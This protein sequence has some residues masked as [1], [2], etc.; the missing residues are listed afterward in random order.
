MSTS[1]NKKANIVSPSRPRHRT[2]PNARTHRQV[3]QP[4]RIGGSY[5]VLPPVGHP[6]PPYQYQPA[7]K[8]FVIPTS[9]YPVT[10]F[11][12]MIPYTPQSA[13][14]MNMLQPP[15]P[16]P[17][18]TVPLPMLCYYAPLPTCQWTWAEPNDVIMEIPDQSS[19]ELE[20]ATEKSVH[21][22]QQAILYHD[23]VVSITDVPLTF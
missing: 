9:L 15:H 8:N 1:R 3:L 12:Q 7:G 4:Q 11:H 16:W 17:C 18:T 5:P 19:E 23:P 6:C 21:C 13:V 20:Q 2:T 22:T 10:V 14:P